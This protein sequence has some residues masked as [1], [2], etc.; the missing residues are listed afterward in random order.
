MKRLVLRHLLPSGIFI[1]CGMIFL[2]KGLSTGDSTGAFAGLLV[3]MAAIVIVGIINSGPIA[4]IMGNLFM[5]LIDPVQKFDRPQPTYGPV[6][7][8]RK[9]REYDEAM[10]E[11]EKIIS[12]HPTEIQP[13]IE[14]MEM[15]MIDLHST[16]KLD[17]IYERGMN[18]ILHEDHQANLTRFH[19]VMKKW[20]QKPTP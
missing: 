20:N 7:A 4:Q 11:Y 17:A 6:R 13:Y 18:A 10:L 9:K 1:L 16:E 15:A 19:E 5:G 8:K 3:M 12:E 14:M 2:K